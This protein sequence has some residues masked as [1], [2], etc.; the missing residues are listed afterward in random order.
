MDGTGIS[1][2]VLTNAGFTL[3]P[4]ADMWCPT[5]TVSRANSSHFFGCSLMP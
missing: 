3:T 5:H 4:A 1:S 2:N